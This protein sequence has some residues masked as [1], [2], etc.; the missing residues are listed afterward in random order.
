[1]NDGNLKL[2]YMHLLSSSGTYTKYDS[3][4]YF[5]AFLMDEIDNNTAPIAQTITY[6]DTPQIKLYARKNTGVISTTNR[7]RTNTDV[8][9]AGRFMYLINYSY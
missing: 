8:A 1:M 2:R 4:W 9:A 5:P 3:S 7:F 6:G